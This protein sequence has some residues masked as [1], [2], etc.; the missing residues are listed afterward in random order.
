MLLM[1]ATAFVAKLQYP[2]A[3]DIVVL[4][5]ETASDISHSEDALY[6]DARE[7]TDDQQ[8]KARRLQKDLDMLQTPRMSEIRDQEYPDPIV[9]RIVLP[10]GVRI[11]RNEPCPCGSGRKYKR[12]HGLST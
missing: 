1:K 2:D 11:S 5:M 3:L 4:G 10:R 6:L 9:P 7:W 12:C 8:L